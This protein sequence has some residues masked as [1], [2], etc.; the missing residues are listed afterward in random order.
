[1]RVYCDTGAYIKALG[2]LERSGVISVH[3]FKYENRSRRITKG[4]IPSDLKYGDFINY[5][6]DELKTTE[7]IS[8]LKHDELGGINSRVA[9]IQEIVGPHNRK[10]AQ[11]FDSAHMTGCKAFLT[12]DKGDL[13]SKRQA[14]EALTGVRVFH[15]PSEWPAFVAYAKNGG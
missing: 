5:T 6:Y 4:A 8:T 3:Q 11:H 13:W 1:M 7:V 9:E 14:L 12:S 2:E 10:D 15:M